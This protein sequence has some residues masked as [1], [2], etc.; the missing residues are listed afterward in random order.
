MNAHS[1]IQ[2]AETQQI[3]RALDELLRVA[4][5][6]RAPWPPRHSGPVSL[7]DSLR[8]LLDSTEAE[9]SARELLD[10]PVGEAVRRAITTLGERLHEIG[11]L[12][13]M[14]DV[15]DRVSG[16]DPEHWD[17][18]TDILDKRWDGIGGWH[19]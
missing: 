1:N 14:G 3:E 2:V 19:C 18:R 15:C 10:N 8:D 4:I 9:S 17:H 6:T 12:K 16:L 13:L 11:G 5:S 7:A